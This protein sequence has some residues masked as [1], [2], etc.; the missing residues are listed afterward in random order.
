MQ[1]APHF[2]PDLTAVD[3]RTHHGQHVTLALAG[4]RAC[5][6]THHS[7]LRLRRGWLFHNR[8]FASLT[9][10]PGRLGMLA[11]SWNRGYGACRE[12]WLTTNTATGQAS[13]AGRLRD[14]PV[15]RIM[16]RIVTAAE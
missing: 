6:T 1:S 8:G 4:V 14:L 10:M 16:L 12:R 9:S 7:F 5:A 2:Y 13:A 11:A 15:I 3:M